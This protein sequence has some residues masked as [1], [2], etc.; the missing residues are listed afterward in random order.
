MRIL[1][2]AK[3]LLALLLLAACATQPVYSPA[4]HPDEPGY[5]ETR[6]TENRYRV[7][8]VGQSG[9]SSDQVKNYALLRA[10]ELTMGAGYDWFQVVDRETQERSRSNEPRVS[11]GVGTGCYP[12]GCRVIGSRWY[13]GA[14]VHSWPYQDRH[15]TSI[16]I[17]MGKGKPED[18]NSVYS[19]EELSRHLRDNTAGDSLD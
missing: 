16:E 6:L 8:F 18:P 2:P 10:A 4:Q 17:L 7:S 9:T 19:A 3:I 14:S 15:R 13:T 5:W 11:I 1:L 12:F